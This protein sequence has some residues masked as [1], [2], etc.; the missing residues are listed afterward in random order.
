MQ[1]KVVGVCKAENAPNIG[2]VCELIRLIPHGEAV[3]EVYNRPKYGTGFLVKYPDGTY[4]CHDIVHIK[5]M[6]GNSP[7]LRVVP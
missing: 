6:S 4:H 1:V 3:P 5:D 2:T 7:E